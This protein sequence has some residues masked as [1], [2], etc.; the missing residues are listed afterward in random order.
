MCAPSITHGKSDSTC[1]IEGNLAESSSPTLL[2]MGASSSIA[3]MVARIIAARGPVG[4]PD[5]CLVSSWAQLVIALKAIYGV[6]F[7][8]VMMCPLIN[9]DM[10][11][12]KL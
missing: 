12:N 7:K 4:L 2:P 9:N 11:F 3:R 5:S 6:P 10:P 8:Q 1:N